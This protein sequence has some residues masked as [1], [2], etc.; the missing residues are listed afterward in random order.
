MNVH[1][2]L[3]VTCLARAG[4]VRKPRHENSTGKKDPDATPSPPEYGDRIWL[5]WQGSA[6]EIGMDAVVHWM[7]QPTHIGQ[8]PAQ[9][10]RED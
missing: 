2:R 9:G 5:L 6:G 10:T 8:Q 3:S 4:P 7:S 1:I